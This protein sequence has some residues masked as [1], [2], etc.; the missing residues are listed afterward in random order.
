MGHEQLWTGQKTL[1]WLSHRVSVHE[2]RGCDVGGIVNLYDCVVCAID[3]GKLIRDGISL[4][5]ECY[6][7]YPYNI[8]KG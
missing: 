2:R 6:I 3:V 7:S 5:Q 1:W 4:V 8:V